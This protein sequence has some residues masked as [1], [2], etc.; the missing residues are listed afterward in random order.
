VVFRLS[1]FAFGNF[2]KSSY[3]LTIA[4]RNQGSCPGEKLS[5]SLCCKQSE[6]KTVRDFLQAI[7]HSNSGHKTFSLEKTS[8]HITSTAAI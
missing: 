6:F 8:M 1:H 5:R 3:D 2:S 4:A 7:L